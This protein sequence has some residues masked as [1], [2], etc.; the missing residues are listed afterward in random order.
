MN[1]QYRIYIFLFFVTILDDDIEDPNKKKQHFRA[2]QGAITILFSE[3]KTYTQEV[4]SIGKQNNL[5]IFCFFFKEF[6]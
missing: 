4:L 1:L 2:L 3:K 6:T 5:Y